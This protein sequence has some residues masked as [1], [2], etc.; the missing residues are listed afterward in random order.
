M[1]VLSGDINIHLDTDEPNATRLKDIFAMFNLKQYVTFATHRLGHTIDVVLTRSDSPLITGLQ[2][3]DVKLSDHF[4]VEFTVGISPI[5]TEYM[6]VTYRDT[7]SLN[8]MQFCTEIKEGYESIPICNMQDKVTSC[9]TL[10]SKVINTHA[11]L[12]TDQ[13][14]V[15]PDAPWFDFECKA[16][17]RR[18][19]KAERRHRKTG[20]VEHKNEFVKL[21]NQTT[22]LAF[23]KKKT[24]Y[25]RKIDE[26]NGNSKSL[27]AC[28]NQLLNIK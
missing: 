22:A 23:D 26:C 3:S 15:V 21:R 14:K 12:K 8:N 17:R 7:K 27:F 4:F 20:W 16:L 28:V 24:Y 1:F 5:K 19:R 18:R 9:H 13:I 11:P 25:V 2:P 6:T 10:T